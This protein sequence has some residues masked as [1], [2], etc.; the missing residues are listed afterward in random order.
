MEL[1][2]L[3]EVEPEP[4]GP[5]PAHLVGRMAAGL[6][7]GRHTAHSKGAPDAAAGKH[8]RAQRT[9]SSEYARRSSVVAGADVVRGDHQLSTAPGLVDAPVL[10][11]IGEARLRSI[12]I[13]VD[14]AED[15]AGV[16][17]VSIDHAGGR[18]RRAHATRLFERERRRD[19]VAK[20]QRIGKDLPAAV[21]GIAGERSEEGARGR[22]VEVEERLRGADREPGE[23]DECAVRV[24]GRGRIC[25]TVVVHPD[26]EVA[27]K[28]PVL[29]LLTAVEPRISA[30]P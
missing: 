17:K 12:G 4:A 2:A 16:A 18:E 9:E 13:E 20:L 7:A 25:G 27:A 19:A 10:Q 11:D 23:L 24:E 15:E 6:G 30:G 26:L 28:G 3:V 8:A 14:G 5:R 21:A 22:R 29:G 1:V